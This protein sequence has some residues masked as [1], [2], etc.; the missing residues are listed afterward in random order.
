MRLG[1]RGEVVFLNKRAGVTE[2]ELVKFSAVSA[3]E[4]CKAWAG[5]AEVCRKDG[6]VGKARH[7]PGS[8]YCE[9]VIVK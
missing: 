9:C 5:I 7:V 3:E 8:Q 4:G 1:R 2:F 6:E